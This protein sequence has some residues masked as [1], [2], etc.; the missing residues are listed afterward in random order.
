MRAWPCRILGGLVL[1]AG[2]GTVAFQSP[3]FE[4]MPPSRMPLP[5]QTEPLPQIRFEIRHSQA[6]NLFHWVDY[7]ADSSAGKSRERYYRHWVLRF[8]PL[9]E[10]DHRL[11]DGFRQV[12]IRRLLPKSAPNDYPSTDCVPLWNAD[13]SRRQAMSVAA[14]GAQSFDELLARLRQVTSTEEGDAVEAALRHFAPRFESIWPQVA[15]LSPFQQALDQYLAQPRPRELLGHFARFYRI[16]SDTQLVVVVGL[17]GLLDAGA[18]THAE[19]SGRHLLIEVRPDDRPQDQVQVIFH[20][21]CHV[22]YNALTPEQRAQLASQFY[23]LGTGGMMGWSLAHEAL[24]TAMGQGLAQ[25]ILTPD[26]FRWPHAWYHIP[27]IDLAAKHIYPVV[28]AEFFAG[29]SLFDQLPLL[30]SRRIDRSAV[31][32]RIRPFDQLTDALILADSPMATKLR[33]SRIPVP[34]RPIYQVDPSRE[35][36][37]QF[38]KRSACLPLIGFITI[39]D[40][41]TLPVAR[42]EAVRLPQIYNPLPTHAAGVITPVRRPSGA[43]ALWV[44]A[45]D[46]SEVPT[47]ID[48][49][50]QLDGW[51]T[52]PQIVRRVTSNAPLQAPNAS[53]SVSINSSSVAVPALR[54]IASPIGI[55]F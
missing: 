42:D 26:L 52:S 22:L 1:L 35:S 8:G 29:R 10:E 40:L 14:I 18:P 55:P 7:L 23:R 9:T 53:R 54:S 41:N 37:A 48:A 2:C 50:T 32:R 19:A 44:I 39:E 28:R 33:A 34:V 3:P 20:E 5:Q 4:P 13:I 24:P 25:A 49:V 47:M 27:E 45:R 17:V 38:I 15:F 30:I 36:G 46:D 43:A 21:L 51:P 16:P 11:L 12:R 31:T 6:T